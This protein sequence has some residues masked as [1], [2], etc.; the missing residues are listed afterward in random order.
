MAKNCIGVDIGSS[1]IKVVQL[2][3]SRGGART[4]L[5]NFGIE[6]VPPEAIVDGSMMNSTDVAD[7]ISSIFR[8]LKIR[9]KEVAVAV[10]GHS[11][12]IKKIGVP[13]MTPDELDEQIHWEAEHHIPFPKSEVEIDYQILDGGGGANQME[14]LLVAAKKEIVTDYSDA[15]RQAQ[16]NPCVVDVAAFS[17]QNCF[18]LAYGKS[19]ETIALLNVGASISSLNVVHAGESQ[20]TRDVTIGGNAFTEEIQKQLNIGYHEA[21]AYKCGGIAGDEVV[22][23]EVD[24]ILLQQAEVMAGEF[25]RSFDFYLATTSEGQIDKVY[26]SGGSARV[27]ALC[28][29]IQS[30]ARLPVELLDP[31][32]AIDINESEFDM[33]YVRSQAPMAAIAVGLA[34]R[35]EGDNL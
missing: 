10:A 15:A 2:K 27:P 23:R 29:A 28:E 1:A 25:Q 20:F 32:A 22:P 6:P 21:E 7:A 4:Q 30:R 18:E 11:V 13:S 33:D 14:V 31:F 5:V 9:S 17:L 34:L 16:L 8:Q 19:D 26:L 12:I 35:R 24:D 3:Q